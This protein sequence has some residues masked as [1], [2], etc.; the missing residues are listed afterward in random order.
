MYKHE[1][2]MENDTPVR[3]PTKQNILWYKV[4]KSTR[5]TRRR[6]SSQKHNTYSSNRRNHN[7]YLNLLNAEVLG[8]Y[9]YALSNTQ[10]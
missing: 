6:R 4:K 7:I 3:S 10:K 5:T 9:I 1:N 2:R 8:C